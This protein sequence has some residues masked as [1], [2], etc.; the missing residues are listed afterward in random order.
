MILENGIHHII[1]K[2][3]FN[4]Q[5][6]NLYILGI[7]LAGNKKLKRKQLYNEKIID[8]HIGKQFTSWM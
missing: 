3:V 2:T 1:G 4:T 7:E 6:P 8:K 5:I